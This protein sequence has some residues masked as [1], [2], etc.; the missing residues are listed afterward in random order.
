MHYI[1]ERIRFRT[2]QVCLAVLNT[3]CYA[4]MFAQESLVTVV[5]VNLI[6]KFL[7]E[8]TCMTAYYVLY[9]ISITYFGT[10][11]FARGS[12]VAHGAKLIAGVIGYVQM[13][14]FVPVYPVIITA[15]VVSA[16]QICDVHSMTEF[17]YI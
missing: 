4:L 1:K 6:V 10:E 17:Q 8:M 15:L 5:I 12:S 9:D 2:L 11:R 3:G 7:N 16:L 14:S 13:V